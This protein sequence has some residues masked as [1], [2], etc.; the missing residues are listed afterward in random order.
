MDTY[1]RAEN[2]LKI[3]KPHLVNAWN[4]VNKDDKAHR[5]LLCAWI[6][7]NALLRQRDRR[8]LLTTIN[9]IAYDLR[10]GDYILS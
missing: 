9:D 3:I 10:H 2:A 4:N 5:E 1:P 8:W 7:E 6:E